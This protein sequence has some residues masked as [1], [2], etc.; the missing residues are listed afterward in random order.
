[1]K[2]SFISKQQKRLLPVKRIINFAIADA[3]KEEYFS[4]PIETTP[5]YLVEFK[6]YV[7]IVQ[8]QVGQRRSHAEAR[9]L[10]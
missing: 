3:G 5:L 7:K 4:R 10:R 1:M 9:L 8:A 2:H 6:R